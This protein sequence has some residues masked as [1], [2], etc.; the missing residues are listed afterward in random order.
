MLKEDVKY[1]DWDGKEQVET[2]YFNISKTELADNLDLEGRLKALSA[3]FEAADPEATMAT[4]DIK[5]ILE[6]V[7]TFM[8]LSYGVRSEDGKRFM[9]S[10]DIYTAFTQTAVYDEFLFSLFEV[11][12]KAIHFL[13]NIIPA[14]LRARAEEEVSKRLET[15]RAESLV[16]NQ[17]QDVPLPIETSEPEYPLYKQERRRAT[18]AELA[19]MGDVE[20][21]DALVWNRGFSE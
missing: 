10:E 3:K 13:T 16:T 20:L 9:K 18:E 7:K 17:S 6:L 21:K 4:E 12:Q 2:L 15:A 5:E 19:A 11:P 8:K 14:D 1:T